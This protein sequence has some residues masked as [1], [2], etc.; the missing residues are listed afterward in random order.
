VH[1]TPFMRALNVITV[2][3][4]STQERFNN[5]TLLWYSSL[6]EERTDPR[7]TYNRKLNEKYIC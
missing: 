3:L 1:Y 7:L 6:I 2:Y 4:S 5:F